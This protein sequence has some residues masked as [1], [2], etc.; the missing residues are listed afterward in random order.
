VT[1]LWLPGEARKQQQLAPKRGKRET[2]VNSQGNRKPPGL[3]SEIKAQ[4][5]K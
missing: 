2:L 4:N 5:G 3:R 1:R